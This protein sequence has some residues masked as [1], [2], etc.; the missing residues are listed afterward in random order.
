[1]HG[2]RDAEGCCSTQS[3]SP[4][5]G[6]GGVLD[7]GPTLAERQRDDRTID[8]IRA[9]IVNSGESACLARKGLV[10]SGGSLPLPGRAGVRRY[11]LRSNPDPS[12]RYADF[13][14]D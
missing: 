3:H 11:H 4:A 12:R 10:E 6:R 1:M 7:P 8:A 9:P 2:P 14:T 13:V 5:C